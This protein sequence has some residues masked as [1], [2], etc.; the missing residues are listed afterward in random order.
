MRDSEIFDPSVAAAEQ[1][2]PEPEKCNSGRTG[3]TSPEGRAA[4]S[5]NAIKHG[6]C[7]QTLILPGESEESWLLLLSRWCKTYQPAEDSL[8]YDFVLKT[9][10]AEWHR[11]RAQ[12]NFDSFNSLTQGSSPFNWTGDQVKKHDLMLRYK[13][14]AERAFQR[15]YRLLEQHYKIH[16]PAKGSSAVKE[17]AAK[18]AAAQ[19][20]DPVDSNTL[21]FA[22]E[23]PNSPTGYTVIEKCV[24][25]RPIPTSPHRR[26][27]P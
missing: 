25:E 26:G 12:R 4:S 7:S 13:A 16:R 10:Q 18:E 14:A 19:E 5:K 6:S 11:I 2:E 17:S 8:E 3:P 15:E 20:P 23:D 27:S 21:T 9:A 1:S 22:E 24:C